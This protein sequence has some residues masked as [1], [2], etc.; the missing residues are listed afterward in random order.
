[1][2]FMRE[3]SKKFFYD[4]LLAPGP[5]GYEQ[6]IQRVVRKWMEPVADLVEIDLHGNVIVA[7]NPDAPRRVMLAGHCDQIGFMVKH[8]TE[9]GF[10]YV[11]PLGGI[12]AGVLPGAK[13]TIWGKKG[14]V[15]GVFGRKPIH[16]QE[17]NERSKMTLDVDKLWMDIGA[18][19]RKEV[20]KLIEI[21]DPITF[22]LGVT[23]LRNGCIVSPGIDNRSG[24]F[25]AMEAL[26]LCAGKKLQVGLFAVSTVQEELGLRGARTAAYGID[27]EVGIAIDVTHA[28][29]DPGNDDAKATPCVLGKG[30]T[31][32]RGPNTNPLV[33]KGLSDAAKKGKIAY[34]LA[35][36]SR[37]FGN[38]ANAMQISRAGV[39]TASIG[40][41][42]RYMH[43]QTEVCHL[44]DVEQAAIL[45]ATFVQGITAKTSFIPE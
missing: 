42:N 33:E 11:S 39:A 25:V 18:K 37:P 35:P 21:G 4:L 40:I 44:K 8:I 31:I 20:E 29:D 9:K 41:P 3:E 10:I 6:P 45:L 12:D 36:S 1:M 24:L 22:E 17:A 34:Q 15:T 43:T 19:D 7:I 32:T 2:R 16:K 13:A 14:P 5:S 27:P 30:P 38:D 28:T 23:E 26:R